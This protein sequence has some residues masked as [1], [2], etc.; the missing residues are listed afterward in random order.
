MIDYLQVLGVELVAP[1]VD[2]REEDGLD[3]VA[4]QL[5]RRLVGGDEHLPRAQRHLRVLGLAQR[6]QLVQDRLHVLRQAR[7]APA[8]VVLATAHARRA[9]YSAQ[10]QIA[11]GQKQLQTMNRAEN[12]IDRSIIIT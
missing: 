9:A 4:A 1:E 12:G 8:E 7:L 5:V 11:S 10:R 2:G 3:L 6:R